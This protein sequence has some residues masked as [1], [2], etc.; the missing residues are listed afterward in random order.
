MRLERLAYECAALN[1]L[2][3]SHSSTASPMPAALVAPARYSRLGFERDPPTPPRTAMQRVLLARQ[4]RQPPRSRRR[5][6]RH[7]PLR[8]G[9]RTG[10][11]DAVGSIVGIGSR[12]IGCTVA[13]R[14]SAGRTCGLAADL[15]RTTRTAF[16]DLRL[17]ARCTH[18]TD[19][20][21][22][23]V[24]LDLPI[25]SAGERRGPLVPA[26]ASARVAK[27]RQTRKALDRL[28]EHRLLD[29]P[30]GGPMDCVG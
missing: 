4:R 3:H 6:R 26:A 16:R 18:T 9:S 24:G 19:L 20:R 29:G 22:A 15:V 10:R 30:T 12:F 17:C 28:A 2:W 8:R 1:P 21:D 11:S 13:L 14:A 25:A 5:H 27:H 7:S 23:G